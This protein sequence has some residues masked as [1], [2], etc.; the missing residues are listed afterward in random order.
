MLSHVQLFVTP[1]TAACQAPLSTA[2]QNLLRFMTIELVMLSNHLILC[3]PFLLLPSSL[4]QY[5]DIF[6]WIG[7]LHQVPKVLEF[8]HQSFLWIF[9]VDFL[10]DWLVK[11]TGKQVLNLLWGSRRWQEVERWQTQQSIKFKMLVTVRETHQGVFKLEESSRGSPKDNNQCPS[12]SYK[13][14]ELNTLF[15][16]AF[17]PFIPNICPIPAAVT[18]SFLYLTITCTQTFRPCR[19]GTSRT[20]VFL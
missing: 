7:F 10:L 1:W 11:K 2:S 12:H 14:L 9:R 5:Q 16:F 13:F 20:K 3:C 8:Q 17:S 18:S 4:T 6:Q 15:S 19:L